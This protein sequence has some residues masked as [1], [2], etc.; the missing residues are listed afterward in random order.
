MRAAGAVDPSKIAALDGPFNDVVRLAVAHKGEKRLPL[1]CVCSLLVELDAA[2]FERTVEYWRT[3]GAGTP[4]AKV[5][6]AMAKQREALEDPELALR[7]AVLL[8]SRPGHVGTVS[9]HG[10]AKRFARDVKPYLEAYLVAK[11]AR[12]RAH[13]DAVEVKGDA[14]LASVVSALKSA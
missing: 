8:S 12:L 2:A 1:D 9:K 13:L 3:A 4:G 10:V 7:V 6:E 11:G 5:I 14:T